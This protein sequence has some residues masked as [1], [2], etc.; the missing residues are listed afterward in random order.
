MPNDDE[1]LDRIKELWEKNFSQ[2]EIL[3][4]LEDEGFSISD[5][6]LSRIRSQNNWMI[7][8]THGFRPTF[9]KRRAGTENNNGDDEEVHEQ[10]LSDLNGT[11]VS[12]KKPERHLH[13]E[14]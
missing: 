12:I 5:R 10:L 13:Q 1:L 6:V 8:G 7:R 4:S 9:S 11:A 2:K 3:S 14:I